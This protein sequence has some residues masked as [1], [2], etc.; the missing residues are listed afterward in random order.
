LSEEEIA[1][2]VQGY[3][4]GIKVEDLANAFGIDQWTVQKYARLAGLDRRSPRL[5]SRQT[6]EAIRLYSQGSPL[7]VIGKT[8]GVSPETVRSALMR[9]G[10]ALRPRRGWKYR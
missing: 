4:E 3:A 6:E 5:G 2:L 9:A 1:S 10:I 8:F 7:K